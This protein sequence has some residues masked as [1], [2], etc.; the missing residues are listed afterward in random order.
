VSSSSSSS[1]NNPTRKAKLRVS[2]HEA[3]V[4]NG[5]DPFGKFS[6]PEPN[7]IVT[8]FQI[9]FSSALSVYLSFPRLV[10]RSST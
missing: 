8:P 4:S 10:L 2:L 7:K 5:L 6:T 9:G 3:A 1:L